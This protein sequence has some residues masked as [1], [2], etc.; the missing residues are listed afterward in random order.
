MARGMMTP[1]HRQLFPGDETEPDMEEEFTVYLELKGRESR[2][3]PLSQR[4]TVKDIEEEVER[5]WRLQ[6]D[7]YWLSYARSMGT[8]RKEDALFTPGVSKDDMI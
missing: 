5:I 3:I 8:L 2:A 7:L 4:T 1:V 6:K